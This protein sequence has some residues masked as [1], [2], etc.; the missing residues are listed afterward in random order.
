LRPR[1][2]PPW[3][4]TGRPLDRRSVPG[5]AIAPGGPRS[6]LAGRG[7]DERNA[8]LDPD[9]DRGSGVLAARAGA[10]SRLAL[11]R[12]G[13]PP[14]DRAE[15]GAGDPGSEERACYPESGAADRA[16]PAAADATGRSLSARTSD[17]RSGERARLHAP[18][19]Q[20]HS[21]AIRVRLLVALVRRIPLC[22]GLANADPPEPRAGR[23]D[24]TPLLSK[25]RDRWPDRRGVWR[26]GL[27]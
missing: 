12:L 23:R 10:A 15:P 9:R 26:S 8:A 27:L 5:V 17:S 19:R 21:G 16:G 13:G 18:T 25:A 11:P 24:C 7:A 14:L 20:S 22:A 3:R 4:C 6:A 2:G 1:P